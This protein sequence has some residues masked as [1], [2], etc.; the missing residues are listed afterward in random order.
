MEV[1]DKVSIV[2]GT[3]SG[4]GL[5]TAKLLTELCAKVALVSRSKEKLGMLSKKLLN[6]ITIPTD[7]TKIPEIIKI[8][9]QTQDHF[10]RIDIV[11]N[12]AGQR[13]DAPVE[14]LIPVPS[15][16]SSTWT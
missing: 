5:A 7:M 9:E 4:I 1:Q 3:S 11:I 15:T 16:T 6:S 2:T 8:V 14:K 12:N 10:G 13:Y